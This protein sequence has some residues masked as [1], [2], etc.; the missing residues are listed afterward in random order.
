MKTRNVDVSLLI[1][2]HSEGI[3]AHSTLNSIE[4]CRQF[5]EAA[6]IT[7]EYV[8]VLDRCDEETKRVLFD[9]PAFRGNTTVVEVSYGDPGASRN[10]GI[11]NSH[12]SAIA[13][14]DGDDYY[15]TNWLERAWHYLREFGPNAILH[16]EF[17]VNFGAHS[18][19]CWHVDQTGKYYERDALLVGNLWSSWTFA[20][21]SVYERCPYV[22]TRPL[23]TG[24]GYEDWHWNCETIA[25]GYQHRLAWG[26][27]A[28]YRRKKQRSVV[29]ASVDVNAIIAPS[30]L[31][32][33]GGD[34]A[35]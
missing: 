24:F 32:A 25:A 2:F 23:E 3:L 9:H 15:S 26:T 14:L 27:V 22:T 21:R 17:V 29:N 4:R 20:H 28:F 13:I 33:P 11:D 10:S 1:T 30:R 19:Y 35:T 12:G 8:W 18:A 31:F 7:T 6:G 16:P 34:N 5:A